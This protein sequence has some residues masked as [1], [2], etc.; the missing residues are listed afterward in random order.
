MYKAD[1]HIHTVLSPCGDLE[2][3]P[4]NIVNKAKERGLNIIGITDHN[5]SLHAAL[6]RDIAKREGIFVLT[7]VEITSREEVHCLGFFETDSELEEFQNFL[8]KAIMKIPN[9]PDKF[10]YQVVVNEQEEIV[11]QIE[12][13]LIVAINK[14]VEEIEKEVHRL[15]GIFILAHIDKKKN[16]ILSQLGFIPTDMNIEGIEF[17][18]YANINGILTEKKYL[19][20]YKYIQSSDAH[21]ID[22]VGSV[23]TI[24][25]CDKLDFKS[26]KNWFR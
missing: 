18:K 24:I 23:F 1:L 12:H 4:V 15:G 14:S 22:D 6:V 2:M 11:N 21:Y 7:G 9:K 8:D 5:T 26:I 16:S 17:S 25:D 3:S 20:K 19:E 13:L 10:G